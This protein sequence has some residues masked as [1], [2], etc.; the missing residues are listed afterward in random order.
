MLHQEARSNTSN[1]IPVI[2]VANIFFK[3]Y[4]IFITSHVVQNTSIL[5]NLNE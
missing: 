1:W 5:F 4:S 3:I 2:L